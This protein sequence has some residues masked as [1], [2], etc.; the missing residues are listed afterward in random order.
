VESSILEKFNS[1]LAFIVSFG[2]VFFVVCAFFK[3]VGLIDWEY[4]CV[5]IPL[6]VSA[7]CYIAGVIVNAVVWLVCKIWDKL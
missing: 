2:C 4:W 1:A 5:C 6:L 3:M 7:I